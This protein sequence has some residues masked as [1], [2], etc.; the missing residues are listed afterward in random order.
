MLI[1]LLFVYKMFVMTLTRNGIVDCNIYIF[2]CIKKYIEILFPSLFVFP[3]VIMIIQLICLFPLLNI[4][5]SFYTPLAV[6]VGYIGYMAYCSIL[7]YSSY[8]FGPTLSSQFFTHNPYTFFILSA[9]YILV[10]S[11]IA[12]TLLNVAYLPFT[13]RSAR[14][15]N[16]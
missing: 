4:L 5:L 2:Q 1:M 15:A 10:I 12:R 3:F 6:L 8:I 11:V 7:A 9:G 13:L 16:K 14:N